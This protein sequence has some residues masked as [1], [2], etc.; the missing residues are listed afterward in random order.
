MFGSGIFRFVG[1]SSS[2]LWPRGRGLHTE[3]EGPAEGLFDGDVSWAQPEDMSH[4]EYLA[5]AMHTGYPA[6]MDLPRSDAAWAMRNMG[7]Q[8]LQFYMVK[9]EA[10]ARCLSTIPDC[11]LPYRGSQK[12]SSCPPQL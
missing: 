3:G 5:V 12:R 2:G 11:R 7:Q 9:S 10:T 1:L 8:V 6:Y 4:G